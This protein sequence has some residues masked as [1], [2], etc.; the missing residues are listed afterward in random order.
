MRNR[1]HFEL[2]NTFAKPKEYGQSHNSDAPPAWDTALDARIRDIW[3]AKPTRLRTV[4]RLLGRR[5]TALCRA[6]KARMFLSQISSAFMMQ[7]SGRYAN[8][9]FG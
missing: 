2:P 8:G 3:P 5:T 4:A 1:D 6:I 9:A 7:D